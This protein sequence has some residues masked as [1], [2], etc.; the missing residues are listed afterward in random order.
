MKAYITLFVFVLSLAVLAA[1]Q[2]PAGSTVNQ[3]ATPP[4]AQVPSNSSDAAANPS[5]PTNQNDSVLQ[6]QIENAIRN[7]PSLSNTRVVVNV[8]AESIDLSGTVDSSKDK[9]AAERIAQSFDGNRKLNDTLMITGQ[10]PVNSPS[11]ANHP[12]STPPQR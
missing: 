12:P 9:L 10:K 5:A 2:A 3:P 6:S 7:E 11:V 1:A 8:S 4:S